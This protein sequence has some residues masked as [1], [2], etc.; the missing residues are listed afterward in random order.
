MK[1]TGLLIAIL[2]AGVSYAQIKFEKGY[3]INNSGEKTEVFIKNMDWRNNPVEFE[4]KSEEKGEIKK[5]S[6]KNIQEFSIDGTSKYIR[7]KVMMDRS[8]A[9]LNRMSD[10]KAPDF[11]EETIFLKYMIEGKA[12]LLYYN[13]RDTKRFFYSINGSEPQ[14]LIYKPYYVTENKVAYNEEYKK[15]I[16]ENLDCGINSKV[17]E[18]AEYKEKNLTHLFVLYNQCSGGG[19]LQY[20]E[21]KEKRDLFNLNIRPGINFSSFS[22]TYAG[23]YSTDK[24]NFANK[25]SFRIGLE[26]EFI[27]PFNKNKWAIFV[28]PT[29]QSYKSEAEETMS[30]GTLFEY[31]MKSNI[32][33]KSIEVPFGIRHYFFLSNNS[34]VFVNAG[35]LI[36][37]KMSSSFTQGQQSIEVKPGGNFLF[38]AGFKY[39]DRFS[40]EVRVGTA[41]SLTGNYRFLSSDYRTASIILGYTL[42]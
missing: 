30:P 38:G 31:K 18:K 37:F 42:F 35:Y 23:F 10:E 7:K 14:Q 16:A 21:E 8:S 40:A 26:A 3:F 5:E 4:Y 29:Y 25:T 34:K 39:N 41:R 15:Q 9:N 17:L 1:K 36:D 11:K 20:E 33:Y 6:I 24:T 32:D 19:V 13:G 2:A 27:L 28:E 22:T 12:S